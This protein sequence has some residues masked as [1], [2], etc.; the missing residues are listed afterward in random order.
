MARVADRAVLVQDGMV[1][2]TLDVPRGMEVEPWKH[3]LV[4]HFDV[5]PADG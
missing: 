3:Q 2:A 4:E 1:A 5:W